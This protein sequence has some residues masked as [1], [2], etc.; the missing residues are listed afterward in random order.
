MVLFYN[1]PENGAQN[2]ILLNL[3]DAAEEAAEQ[4]ELNA[5]AEQFNYDSLILDET[6]QTIDSA[7]KLIKLSPLFR[8]KIEHKTFRDKYNSIIRNIV[9]MYYNMYII[10]QGGKKE[11]DE[12]KRD[13]KNPKPYAEKILIDISLKV[14]F[15]KC[16]V[17]LPHKYGIDND[18]KKKKENTDALLNFY[19]SM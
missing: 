13:F 1:M 3:A 5:M 7:L 17:E 8:T 4:L 14:A 16:I 9:G 12:I 6:I 15:G 19:Q 10:E 18:S 2:N 11:T